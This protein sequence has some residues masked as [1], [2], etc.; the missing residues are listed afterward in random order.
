MSPSSSETYAMQPLL[1]TVA[2][3]KEMWAEDELYFSKSVL[4]EE[5]APTAL[6]M[7]TIEPYENSHCRKHSNV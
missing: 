7:Y 5:I 3:L 6:F 2:K 4:I 1:Q